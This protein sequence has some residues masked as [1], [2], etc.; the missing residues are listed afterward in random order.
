MLLKI[1]GIILIVI[2]GVMALG[3]LFPL[4]GSVLGFV[5]LLVKLAVA[6]VILFFGYRLLTRDED[7]G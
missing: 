1:L 6:L 5:V 3:V 4:I 2:G 7:Y